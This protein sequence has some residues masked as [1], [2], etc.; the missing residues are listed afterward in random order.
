MALAYEV[1]PYNLEHLVKLLCSKQS[2]VAF[3][4]EKNQVGYLDNYLSSHDID[5]RTIIAEYGYVDRDYLADYVG[6]YA[7]CFQPY[8]RHCMRLHFFSFNFDQKQFKSL[9]RNEGTE[10]QLAELKKKYVG[11]VVIKPLPE[12]MIGRTCLKTY[13]NSCGRMFPTIRNYKVNLLVLI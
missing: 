7:R 11:F 2:D 3:V 1:V 10:L 9:L 13:H 6:Y 5:A 8:D 12:T 4:S